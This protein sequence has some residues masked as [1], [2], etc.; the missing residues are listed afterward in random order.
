MLERREYMRAHQDDI[1]TALI[2]EPRGFPAMVGAL[3]TPP[4]NAGSMAGVVFFNNT[5]YLGMC[6]HGLMGVVR[7]LNHL[8]RLPAGVVRVDTPA[9]TVSATLTPDGRIE[10]E[11]VPSFCYRI[12]AGVEVDGLGRVT[13][14]IAYGGN[15]FFITEPP[16]VLLEMANC[17][18]LLDVTDRIARALRTT[19]ITGQDG[20][21]IDHVELSG[22]PHRIDAD[23]RNFVLCPGGEFDRS[24]CGTGTS[25]KLASLHARGA[26]LPGEEYRQESITGSLFSARLTERDGELVPALSGRAFIT[27]EAT[28][29]FQQGDP[30]I[31]GLEL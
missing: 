10:I 2:L 5:G 19:G 6:G 11:N 9:G 29:V 28:L 14:D 18:E 17:R 7:T 31:R 3:L 26:L 25:A 27:A 30:F 22:P 23:S 16:G 15:W 12:D 20:A 1:R 13:G 4:V 8:G 24:P 21:E